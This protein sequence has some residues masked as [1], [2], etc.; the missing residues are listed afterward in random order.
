LEHLLAVRRDANS[1]VED[2]GSFE[3]E[4]H[5]AFAAAEAEAIGE[6]LRRFDIDLPVVMIAGVAHRRVL[7]S[8]AEYFTAA[9]PVRVE[10]TLYSTRDEGERASCP[11][12]LRAGVVEKL[13]TPLAAKQAT[14]VVAHV[15]PQEGEDLFDLL[16]GMAPS[17]SALDRLPKQLSQRWERQRVEF[18]K[19]LRAEEQIPPEAVTVAV[20][21]DGVMVATKD[22]QRREKRAEV[23]ALGRRSNGPVGHHEVGCGTLSL[24]DAAGER[25]DTVRFGRMYERKKLTLKSTLVDE[26]AWVLAQRPDL[27]LVKL[28]DSAQ[29]NWSFLDENLPEGVSLV[30]FFHAA[31][32]LKEALI[33]AYGEATIAF[34]VHFEKHL[35]VLRHELPGVEKVIRALVHLRKQNPHC[36]RIARELAYFRSNR[37]RMRYAEHAA[38]NLPIGSGVV[39]ATC[40]SL[41][42]QRM[43]RSGMRWLQDGGQAILTFRALAQSHRF[44]GG[45]ALIAKTYHA[46]V[47]LPLNVVPLRPRQAAASG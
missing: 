33:P 16:G 38:A 31:E 35:H 32:H 22:G 24:Y 26:L 7:R 43:K 17:R 12:E 3:R 19:A 27:K 40:K 5:A 36:K 44:P 23:A 29:D 42:A 18:E 13:W 37:H 15:T 9:G 47:Q 1:P 28:S 11:M 14:W 21:L 6:E 2:L 25:L 4:L 8:E 45:W 46:D 41:V 39:E 20:S 34:Q 10:R 30:D